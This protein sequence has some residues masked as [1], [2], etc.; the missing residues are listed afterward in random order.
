MNTAPAP[1]PTFFSPTDANIFRKST[2]ETTTSNNFRLTSTKKTYAHI[3]GLHTNQPNQTVQPPPAVGNFYGSSR[4]IQQ[5][6][7]I[8]QFTP[9][10]APEPPKQ[11]ETPH[12][13]TSYQQQQP[14]IPEEPK[15]SPKSSK[16]SLSSLIPTQILDKIPVNSFLAKEEFVHNKS[17]VSQAYHPGPAYEDVTFVTSQNQ[18]LVQTPSVEPTYINPQF[19]NTSPFYLTPATS[20]AQ[21]SHQETVPVPQEVTAQ[22]SA[23]P[24]TFFNP[25]SLQ[26]KPVG[27]TEGINKN[28][29]SSGIGSRFDDFFYIKK[30]SQISLKLSF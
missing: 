27:P 5:N 22:V 29:Y 30:S 17:E 21:Q 12:F 16:F 19:F 26:Q 15:V 20:V 6:P 7:P 2:Q 24:P 28:P 25:E 13:E 4:P 14:F 23:P 8:Q 9:I 1:P 3:P 11:Q 18:A 10:F